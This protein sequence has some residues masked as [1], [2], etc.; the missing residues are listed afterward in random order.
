MQKPPFEVRIAC[1]KSQICEFAIHNI[2]NTPIHN[3]HNDIELMFV[4]DG[5][6]FIDYNLQKLSMNVG[7]IIVINSN[8]LHR[9][10]SENNK[11]VTYLYLIIYQSFC[12]ELGLDITK[13]IFNNKI[14]SNTLWNL[15]H[16][17]TYLKQNQANYNEQLYQLK[18]RQ[19]LTDLLV[20]L[21]ENN[22]SNQSSK[23]ISKHNTVNLLK[24]AIKY[25]NENYAKQLTLEEIANHLSISKFH[26]SREFKKYAGQTL[27]SYLNAVRCK[28][29]SQFILS[30]M[31]VSEAAYK[32]GFLN[33]PYFTKTFYKH[34]GILPSK[35][36]NK[37]VL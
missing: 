8:T 21:L 32:C 27:F 5:C 14:N 29:A 30:G 31:T 10:Y 28:N 9:T 25:V 34:V 4:I 3:W 2:T 16:K 37:I 15:Y 11:S 23:G 35:I 12:E 7:D 24:N 6:G 36:K 1:N 26:L 19:I 20:E 33:M 13:Y 18:L 17:L 22:L